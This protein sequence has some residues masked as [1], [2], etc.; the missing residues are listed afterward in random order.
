MV[1]FILSEIIDL[2][3]QEKKRK[4]QKISILIEFRLSLNKKPKSVHTCYLSSLYPYPCSL[5]ILSYICHVLHNFTE[6]AI[7]KMKTSRKQ[8]RLNPQGFLRFINLK[9]SCH[10][11]VLL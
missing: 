2:K 10:K 11:G 8:E 3:N 4:K 6:N 7:Q 1:L 9:I 5:N